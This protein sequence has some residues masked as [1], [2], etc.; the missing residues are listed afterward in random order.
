MKFTVV[1]S[2]I[3]CARKNNPQ[4]DADGYRYIA[5]FDAHVTSVP[6]HV[7]AKLTAAEVIELAEFLQ[8]REQLQQDTPQRTMIDA[9]PG[10]LLNGVEVL[11][12]VDELNADT[13][14]RLDDT[15]TRLRKALQGVTPV[16]HSTPA[17]LRRMRQ[18]DAQKER[19][20]RLKQEL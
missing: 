10:L 13:Y 11:D 17:A 1:G 19:L 12:D 8:E 9:L 14:R 18:A 4:V 3:I 5:E 7:A 15:V 2:R 6:P 16:S 20:E